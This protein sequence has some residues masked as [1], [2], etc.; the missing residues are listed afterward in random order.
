MS[1]QEART[2]TNYLLADFQHEMPTTIRVIEAVP[3][4]NLSYTPDAKSKTG[5]ALIR[6]IVIDDAWFFNCIAN[7]AFAGGTNDQSDACGIM[8]PAD[9][10]AR[11]NETVPAAVARVAALS[12]EK[13]AADIDFFGMMMMPA[14]CLV[15]LAVKHSVHHRGQLSSYLRAMGGKVPGIYGPSGDSQ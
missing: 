9:G 2:I 5:L 12:D 7:G 4:D 1:P 3:S 10:A 15:G 6:H 13:L 8:T 14:A 11:Y